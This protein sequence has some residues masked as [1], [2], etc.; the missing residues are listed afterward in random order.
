MGRFTP[1][2]PDEGGCD[3]HFAAAP[4]HF[5]FSS[6]RLFSNGADRAVRGG[7]RFHP[8]RKASP[9]RPFFPAAGGIM[10]PG[11]ARLGAPLLE[12]NDLR[13]R[14]QGGGLSSPAEWRPR[15]RFNPFRPEGRVSGR[16]VYG[17]P[18]T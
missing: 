17:K 11:L 3:D 12:E 10:R 4:P 5:S 15:N 2:L 9:R 18:R 14:D 7:L 16:V 13:R 6:D 8:G 1:L